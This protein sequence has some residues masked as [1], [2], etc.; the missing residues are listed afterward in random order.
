MAKFGDLDEF[1]R[2]LLAEVQRDNQLPA[3]VLAERINLSESAVLRRLRHLR[4]IGAITADVSIVH[5]DILGRSL[6][7][8]VL[9]SLERETSSQI[10]AFVQRIRL[11]SEVRQ[12]WYV[13]GDADFV[14]LVQVRSMEDY[15]AFARET[16]HDDPNIRAFKTIIAMRTLI[17][18]PVA[19]ILGS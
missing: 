6:T 11:R 10:G 14:L 18:L 16:F 1:D 3:R 13:T 9:V 8:H 17:E 5:P 4:R 2:A 15:E 7:I 19:D 12:A